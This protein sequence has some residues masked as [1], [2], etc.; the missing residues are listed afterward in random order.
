MLSGLIHTSE[1]EACVRMGSLPVETARM[2]RSINI[3]LR[4]IL[5]E[6]KTYISTKIF[7]A[8]RIPQAA[9]SGY[10]QTHCPVG[11]AAFHPQDDG[12]QGRWQNLVS[13]KTDEC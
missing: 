13:T 12:L 7:F 8:T 1:E 10:V 3:S 4:D 6:Y 9:P 5:C 11:I 2:S